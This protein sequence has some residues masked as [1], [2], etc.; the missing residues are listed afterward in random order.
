MLVTLM[1]GITTMF[2]HSPKR[3]WIPT[4]FARALSNCHWMTDDSLPLSIVVL[5]TLSVCMKRL[6]RYAQR[7]TLDGVG[8]RSD[9]WRG[10]FGARFGEISNKTSEDYVSKSS[11]VTLEV[12]GA[13]FFGVFLLDHN[14]L[15]KHTIFDCGV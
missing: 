3:I 7:V 4:I 5:L 6:W 1:D 2:S 15:A 12:V 14:K 9:G 10:P 11:R 8:W 13:T